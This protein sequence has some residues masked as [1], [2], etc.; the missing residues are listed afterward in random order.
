MF[1]NS[2]MSDRES[3]KMYAIL[4][5]NEQIGIRGREILGDKSFIAI[6]Y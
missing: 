6:I 4:F 5:G 3:S 2:I 1:S